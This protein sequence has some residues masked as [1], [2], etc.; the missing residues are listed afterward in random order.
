MTGI[1]FLQRSQKTNINLSYFLLNTFK[2]IYIIIC[3]NGTP[4]K[5][6]RQFLTKL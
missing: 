1:Y 5:L 4:F 2:K 6:T 3:N